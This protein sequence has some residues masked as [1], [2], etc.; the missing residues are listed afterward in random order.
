MAILNSDLLLVQRGSTPQ[1]AE[2]SVLADYVKGTIEATDLPIASAGTLGAI[3]VGNNLT[4]DAGTGILSA[5]IPAG[6]E[7]R[8]T[9]GTATTPPSPLQ[10][11]YFWLWNGGPATLTGVAWGTAE[12]ETLDDGDKIYYN[13][14]QFEVIRD[15]NSG[16]IVVEII[17]QGPITVD[18]TDPT[19]PEVNI[20]DATTA[21]SGAM[22]AADKLKLDSIEAGAEANVSQNLGYTTGANDGTVTITDGTSATIPIASNTIAGLMS[23]TD[24]QQLDSLVANPGGITSITGGDGITVSNLVPGAPEVSVTFGAAPNGTP[25]TVMPYD[26]SMLTELT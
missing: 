25:V 5:E 1:K 23:S 3:R 17:P 21:A 12:N 18:N 26:I 11:G 15:P 20:T 8:G 6:L 9:Y 24:K 13:G 7:Y 2:A 16:G 19:K 14:T 22:S 10:T 4:I